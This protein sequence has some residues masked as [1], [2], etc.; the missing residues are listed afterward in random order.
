MNRSLNNE[1]LNKFLQLD[2]SDVIQGLKTWQKDDDK[3]LSKISSMLINRNLLKIKVQNVPFKSNQVDEKYQRLRK[4]GLSEEDFKFFVF[5]EVIS[6]QT[7]MPQDNEI[8]IMDK[9]GNL[10]GLQEADAFF[11]SEE[12]SRVQQKYFLCFPR[13]KHL[14]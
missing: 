12:L 10:K 7:F 2:D 13:N 1:Q 6:N 11:D 3:V 9:K 14:T 5:T 4:Q 8:L